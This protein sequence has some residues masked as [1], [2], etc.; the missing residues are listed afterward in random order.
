MGVRPVPDR[1]VVQI[2]ERAGVDPGLALASIHAERA[3]SD[4]LAAAWRAIAA[5]LAA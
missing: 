5:R 4:E 2:A 1:F 3:E